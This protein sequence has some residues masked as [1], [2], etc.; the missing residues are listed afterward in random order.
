VAGAPAGE[1]PRERSGRLLL[2]LPQDLHTQLAEAA[3][4]R[5]VSL[6]S[7]IADLLGGAME[8]RP[9]ERE[10]AEPEPRRRPL[11]PLLVINAIVV[12]L[13][14]LAGLALLALALLG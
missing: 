7:L 5:G 9:A 3:E 6:N 13:A 10:P 2:R 14:A 8:G 4:R 11:T 1:P 12:A